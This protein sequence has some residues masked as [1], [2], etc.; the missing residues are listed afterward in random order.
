VPPTPTSRYRRRP[1]LDRLHPDGDLI[2]AVHG[3]NPDPFGNDAAV[4][5]MPLAAAAISMLRR[6][7]RRSRLQTLLRRL[8]KW[9]D[10]V[11]IRKD[12]VPS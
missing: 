4:L 8:A 11:Q 3:A 2:P 7:R 9:D 6:R 5:G 1:D 12:V 10:S